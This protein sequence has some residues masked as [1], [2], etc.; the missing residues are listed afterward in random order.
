MI[1]LA[2]YPRSGS[3]FLRNVFYEV[4]G[5]A[6]ST[7][8][9]ETDYEID[10]AYE[11][12]PVVKTHLLPGQLM[13]DNTGIPSIYLVR[14]G[15]DCLVSLVH[16][17]RQLQQ[18][19]VDFDFAL[20]EAIAAQ[21]G[22][23]FG[24]WGRHAREWLER[25]N[26]V[27]RFEDLV[28]DPLKCV[29]SLSPYLDL[30]VARHE[31]LPSFNDLRSKDFQYGCGAEH[32]FTSQERA[33]WRK[34]KFRRGVVGGW[35]DD[36]PHDL[37]VAFTAR[38][39]GE[40]VRL[41][42]IES[43]K[44]V[45]QFPADS[46]LQSKG[47]HSTSPH[48]ARNKRVLVDGTKLLDYRID[49]IHRYVRELLIAMDRIVQQ[50]GNQWVIDVSLGEC[51]IIPI[52][53]L[54]K[55]PALL[56]AGA[57][58][59]IARSKRRLEQ[60][61]TWS[62]KYF[63]EL[64]KY[65][66]RMLMRSA[67]KRWLKVKR[68]CSLEPNRYDLLHLT[69]PNSWRHYRHLDLP[70]L[71]TVHDLSHLLCPEFQTDSNNHSLRDGCSWSEKQA[72]HYVA[73]SNSTRN[74]LINQLGIGPGRIDVVHNAISESFQPVVDRGLLQEAA[75]KYRLPDGPFL[76]CLGTIEPRKNLLNTIRG[77][78][79]LVEARPDLDIHLIVAGGHG[80]QDQDELEGLIRKSARV[81]QIGYVG[82]QY[83]PALYTLATALCYV[84]HY[85]GFG[86]PLIEAMACGTAVI[87]GDNSSM[88]EIVGDAGW[89][90]DSHD[91]KSIQ[92]AMWQAVFND[93]SRRELEVRATLRAHRFTW[94]HSARKMLDC[95]QHVIHADKSA[96]VAGPKVATLPFPPQSSAPAATEELDRAA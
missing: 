93:H 72:T 38:C 70:L 17:R 1:W 92:D 35:K 22:S 2:S 29:E 28:A 85:E 73:V 81:R 14:D 50:D 47:K 7:Y 94:D 64:G 68:L 52:S 25:A 40:L 45:V 77:F 91:P 95:Y 84:S 10:P 90:A 43:E 26:V 27:I 60:M 63:A 78:N 74:Q 80:W 55:V 39:G 4:Y 57:K 61:K 15:R 31:R 56:R 16:Y 67:L 12:F 54:H 37:Q 5:I 65:R 53:E 89:P 49:G 23:Y 3:T 79:L 58:N 87:Y 88:P 83:L 11:S 24:G 46:F 32:G 82:D 76:L 41:G 9:R 62:G 71:T 51:G 59:P 69:L 33:Q 6:S 34:G 19:S 8:H 75:R 42:Y 86:L 36:L 21:K 44:E 20:R 96:C 18:D 13:P 30:S 48:K 66:C